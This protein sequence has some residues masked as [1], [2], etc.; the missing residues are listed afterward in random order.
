MQ[1]QNRANIVRKRS[2]DIVPS[3][4]YAD[5]LRRNL[6]GVPL[7]TEEA[8]EIQEDHHMIDEMF[9]RLR[10]LKRQSSEN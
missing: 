2:S 7:P 8:Q 6:G 3:N 10:R 4:P 5:E 1:D 9:T